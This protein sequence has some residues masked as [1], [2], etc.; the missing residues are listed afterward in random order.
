MK[1]IIIIGGGIAGLSAGIHA[2]QY[3]F[4]SVIYEKHS[5]VGGQCTGWDRKGYHI[6]GC[7]HWLTGTKEGSDLYDVW[8]NVGALGDTEII[9]LDNFGVHEFEEVT[10]TLWKDLDR[11]QREWTQLSPEDTQ[12]INEFITDVR[13]VQ[14]MEMPAKMPL[15]MLPLK[16]LFKLIKAMKGAGG[17]LNKAG[18]ISC[19][20]YGQRFHH[21]A[22]RS[23]F[24][25]SMPEGYSIIAF[26]FSMG[27][28][29]SGNGAI[30]KD[31]SKAMAL[32]MEKR[33]KDLGGKLFTNISA[34]EIIIR[35]KLATGVRFSDGT[36][37]NSDYVIAAN[38]VKITFDKLLKGKY[39]DKKFDMR[40]NNPTDYGLPTSIQVS[41]GV[42]AD[43]SNYPC[44]VTFPTKAYEIGG[45]KYEG[46]GI[47]NYSYESSFAPEGC[48][49]VTATISLTDKDYLYWERLAQDKVAYKNEKQR[50]GELL[51][52][53]IELRFPEL[54]NKMTLLDVATPITYHRYTGAYHGAWMSF[55]MTTKSKSMMHSGKIKGLKNCYLT[56]QWLEPPGGLPVAVTTGKFTVLRI[57]KKEKCLKK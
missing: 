31:G 52:E 55:M 18:K 50:I 17:V 40:Y 24:A 4:E 21:P 43:L 44:T 8:K 26:I 54:S 56:G 35:D 38:D 57:C 27:T 51:Q 14:S 30:P 23:L 16:D 42:S 3:G 29:T 15:N 49:L 37:V 36:M 7:I 19:F 34:E 45:N 22:L 20:E 25:N 53:R 2:Q 12:A 47:K 32:R 46:M 5:V 10:L 11:L 6:D 9:Q 41:F 39:Q 28:F 13:A 33:Y 1:K 48:T